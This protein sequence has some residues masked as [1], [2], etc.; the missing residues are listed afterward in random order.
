MPRQVFKHLSVWLSTLS[1]IA[2]T[3]LKGVATA[4]L[5]PGMAAVYTLRRHC[6]AACIVAVSFVT[7]CCFEGV[8]CR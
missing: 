8:V 7:S 4:S 6:G 5:P 1:C 3:A 2:S